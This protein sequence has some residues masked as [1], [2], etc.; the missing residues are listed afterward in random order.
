[1]ICP[2]MKSALSDARKTI[3]AAMSS[4]VPRRRA[5][6]PAARAAFLSAPPREAVQ[7]LSLHGSGRD[8]VHTYAGGS[9]LESCRFRESLD[10]MRAGDIHRRTGSAAAT[11]GRKRLAR[12]LHGARRRHEGGFGA[13]LAQFLGES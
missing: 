11:E 9:A 2:V 3:V 7:Q 8:C 5:G 10:R 12:R 13:E 1:M 6:T 4:G